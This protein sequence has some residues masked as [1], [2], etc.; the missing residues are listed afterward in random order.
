M[1]SSKVI[2][3]HRNEVLR[4]FDI[5]KKNHYGEGFNTGSSLEHEVEKLRFKHAHN[6]LGHV[7]VL[8]PT[9]KNGKRPDAV[10]LDCVLGLEV[11]KS[12]SEE[13]LKSKKGFYP[14]GLNVEIVR[15]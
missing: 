14:P 15:L 5:K 2:E 3:M 9:L 7:V 1:R 6:N 13:S 4:L 12:E 10:C 11:A 8:E